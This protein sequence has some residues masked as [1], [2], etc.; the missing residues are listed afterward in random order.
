MNVSLL[1]A[2]ADRPAELKA[3]LRA[4]ADCRLPQG[5]FEVVVADNGTDAETE[6]ICHTADSRLNVLHLHVT[7]RGKAIALILLAAGAA[8]AHPASAQE[9]VR[10]SDVAS[11]EAIVAATYESIARAPGENFDW[12]RFRSLFLPTA[13]LI[14][15]TEQRGGSFDILSV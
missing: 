11:P 12:K 2:T 15:S 1:I 14:P 8:F 5:E 7:E 6:L 4:L 3:T 9:S 13:T 10:S